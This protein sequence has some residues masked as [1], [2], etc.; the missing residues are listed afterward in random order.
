MSTSKKPIL[1]LIPLACFAWLPHGMS[2]QEKAAKN[3]PVSVTGC[4]R[5]GSDK[6]GYF[7]IAADG[8]MYELFGKG[9]KEHVNH[10]VAL[11]GK[12]ATMSREEEA[13]RYENER[14]ESE[15]E[16]IYDVK[17]SSITMVSETCPAR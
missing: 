3:Q 10:Q 6:G 13:I 15:G 16:P 1:F 5:A 14:S 4:L 11:T 7:I 12:T 8:T 9:M 17:V 2:G